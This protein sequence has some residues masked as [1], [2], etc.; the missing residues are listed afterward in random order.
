MD[1]F[2]ALYIEAELASR[3]IPVRPALLESVARPHRA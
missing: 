3:N 1:S 2:Q